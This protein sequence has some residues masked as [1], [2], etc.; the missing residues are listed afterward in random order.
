MTGETFRSHGAVWLVPVGVVLALLA[1]LVVG[2]LDPS[3]DPSTGS[4]VE[5][6]SATESTEARPPPAGQGEGSAEATSCVQELGSSA[7]DGAAGTQTDSPSEAAERAAD[8]GRLT[9]AERARVDAGEEATRGRVGPPARGDSRPLAGPPRGALARVLAGLVPERFALIHEDADSGGLYTQAVFEH[10]AVRI[11][12]V[13]YDAFIV[14]ADTTLRTALAE[15]SGEH[16]Q[17]ETADGSCYVVAQNG[18]G[19]G[20][21][22]ALPD[23]D[24]LV[25]SNIV[26]LLAHDQEAMG[27][28]AFDQ[29]I[30]GLPTRSM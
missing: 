8:P 24:V 12:A 30:E 9:R 20:A 3:L 25:V 5:V 23:G 1:T 22:V 10:G 26:P 27:I 4:L 17:G 13:R 11:S 19:A 14:D 7:S 21:W 18:S 15:A 2:G 16:W 29:L 28:Q 6:V